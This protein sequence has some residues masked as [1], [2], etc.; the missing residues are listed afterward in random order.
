MKLFKTLIRLVALFGI[1]SVFLNP[2]YA[3][4]W[5]PSTNAPIAFWTAIASS[6]DGTK[7]AVAISGGGIYTSTNFG[8]TWISNSVP[9]RN[10]S[11]VA[12]SADG[13]KLIAGINVI[14]GSGL[15][16]IYSST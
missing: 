4:T 9:A 1:L 3:Q 8:L 5:T 16:G 13:R 7:L 2:A 10:W 15:G 6:A 14:S 12:S 11:S